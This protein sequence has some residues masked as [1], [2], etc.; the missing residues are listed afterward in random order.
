MRARSVFVMALA[1]S[2]TA[3]GLA[4]AAPRPKPKPQPPLCNVLTDPRGDN[5]EV[6]PSGGTGPTYDPN[7]D[8]LSAD[9]GHNATVVTGV[10]RLARL[11]ADDQM[12]PTGR[13]YRIGFLHSSSGQ[14]DELR[15]HITVTGT[16]YE[17]Q[18]ATGVLDRAKGEVHISAPI[19]AITG[20]PTYAKGDSVQLSVWADIALPA[21]PGSPKE[22]LGAASNEEL[23]DRGQAKMPYPLYAPSCVTPGA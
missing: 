6:Q 16:V 1:L 12:A 18:G 7:L 10:I 8:I 20:H 17:P 11:D 22:Q 3:S 21:V 2:L 15:A 14:T 19:S 9:I 5:P 4:S 13:Y 23:G